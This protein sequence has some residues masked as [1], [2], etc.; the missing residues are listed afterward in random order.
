ME[1]ETDA[2]FAGCIKSRKSTRGSITRY[3]TCVTSWRS[4]TIKSVVTSSMEAEYIEL[5]ETGKHAQ[6]ERSLLADI[7]DTPPATTPVFTDNESA[8]KIAEARGPTKKS[9][10]IVVRYHHVRDLVAAK[11][12]STHHRPSAD[13]SADL[14]TKNI[15]PKLFSRHRAA[16]GIVP[17]PPAGTVA[18]EAS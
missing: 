5:S 9:K 10:F 16:M 1:S 12:I 17:M 11:K 2:D 14:L 6:W 7:L 8:R 3:S 13:L 18:V 15:G 4:R